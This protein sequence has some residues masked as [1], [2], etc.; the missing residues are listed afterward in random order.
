MTVKASVPYPRYLILPSRDLVLNFRT[1]V[2]ISQKD[3]EEVITQ[4]FDSFMAGGIHQ[5]QRLSPVY[6]MLVSKYETE[7]EIFSEAFQELHHG[8]RVCLCSLGL[9]GIIQ[10]DHG[11][12]NF[13]FHALRGNDI[14]AIHLSSTPEY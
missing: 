13:A 10:E 1:K 4:I 11:E 6:G 14:V 5:L 3:M 12:F 2:N 7:A 9:N 8:L